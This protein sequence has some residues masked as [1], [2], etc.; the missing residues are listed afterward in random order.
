LLEDGDKA[1]AAEHPSD[2]GVVEIG[3]EG[4]NSIFVCF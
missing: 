1:L 2:R 3:Q 4:F